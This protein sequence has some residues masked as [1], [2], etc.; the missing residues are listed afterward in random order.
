MRERLRSLLTK[1]KAKCKSSV[2]APPTTSVPPTAPVTIPQGNNPVPNGEVEKPR[3]PRDLEDLLDFIEG[4]PSQ[5]CK[6]EKKAA[7]KARQKQKKLE[8]IERKKREEEEAERRRIEEEE[9][10]RA[11]LKQQR[12]EA[13]K[14]KKKKKALAALTKES[15]QSP[16]MVTI[17]RVME[18]HSAEPTVTITLRGATP[19][20]DK[21]LYTLLNGKVCQI[22]KDSKAKGKQQTVQQSSSSDTKTKSVQNSS[23]VVMINHNGVSRQSNKVNNK[24]KKDSNSNNSNT[25]NSNTN[26][27]ST[28][29]SNNNSQKTVTNNQQVKKKEEPSCKPPPVPAPPVVPP[30]KLTSPTAIQINNAINRLS[31]RPQLPNNFNL[32]NLKL[33]PGITITKVDASHQP[34]RKPQPQQQKPN[35]PPSIPTPPPQMPAASNVIVVDTGKLKD[36][37][38]IPE[39]DFCDDANGKKKKKKKNGIGNNLPNSIPMNEPPSNNM[40]RLTMNGGPPKRILNPS[41]PSNGKVILPSQAAIIKLNGSMVTIR[42]PALQQALNAKQ[43]QESMADQAKKKKK[44]KKGGNGGQQE[45]SWSI[46]E[47]SVFAPKD[48]DLENGEIDDA[49]RELEAFKR[50]CLQSVPPKRKEKVHLNIKDIVLKKKSTAITCS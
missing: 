40:V 18:P 16:Q 31:S 4:N 41:Q 3:D 43:P 15:D 2:A 9:A 29:N 19:N 21:V 10:A 38:S 42:S 25:N 49:E 14:A 5:K 34:Q 28:N 8:E 11:L 7:K 45:E 35:P 12:K 32:D 37:S 46:D 39:R 44:K 23:S 33:P 26:N 13:K 20:Q 30:P 36:L 24:S 48:I 27:S 50:F 6:D 1:K 47:E 17:K 22:P